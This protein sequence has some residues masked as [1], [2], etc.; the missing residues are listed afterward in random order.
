MRH[1]DCRVT[2]PLWPP[3]FEWI[4]S[5][6]HEDKYYVVVEP[7]NDGKNDYAPNLLKK[8]RLPTKWKKK[9]YTST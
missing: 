9:C 4:E 5:L 8:K 2:D 7:D 1:F 6:P 3:E